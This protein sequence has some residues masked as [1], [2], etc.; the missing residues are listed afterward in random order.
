MRKLYWRGLACGKGG[1]P[2]GAVGPDDMAAGSITD[3]LEGR[4]TWNK[5]AEPD[6]LR[7][8]MDVV[9]S[10]VNHLA[11]RLENRVTRE[12]ETGTADHA[13]ER[14][15]RP[16]P[17]ADVLLMEKEAIVRL[18]TAMIDGIGRDDVAGK[19]FECLD[20][21]ITKPSEMAEVL[22]IP[23]ADVNNAQK[24][25]RRIADKACAKLGVARQ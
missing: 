9:D 21:D 17:A 6:F 7:F 23:I 20:A 22:G 18:K 4:R 5:N 2:P 13:A 8:L 19:V 11:E 14:L 1:K 3:F 25:L 16:S 24:R 10:K 15:V 12:S